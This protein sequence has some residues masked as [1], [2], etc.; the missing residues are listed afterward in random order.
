[1]QQF[2]G[3]FEITLYEECGNDA[4]E[5]YD[6]G[7]ENLNTDFESLITFDN[8]ESLQSIKD[9]LDYGSLYSECTTESSEFPDVDEETSKYDDE[10]TSEDFLEE[11]S[12]LTE[13]L[14]EK[15]S[16]LT[17]VLVGNI[18][19]GCGG[20]IFDMWA[21]FSPP[22][23]DT[24]VSTKQSLS[25]WSHHTDLSRREFLVAKIREAVLRTFR[26]A[27]NRLKIEPDFGI[28]SHDEE[29][30]D[31]EKQRFEIDRI[32]SQSI[33]PA[34]STPI[35]HAQPNFKDKGPARSRILEL[36]VKANP[37][38]DI[39]KLEK[40]ADKLYPSKKSASAYK[41]NKSKRRGQKSNQN[42]QKSNTFDKPPHLIK[43]F[44]P[45]C[46]EGAS[47]VTQDL[48]PI[49]LTETP[50]K[51]TLNYQFHYGYSNQQFLGSI[52]EI[53]AGYWTEGQ[54]YQADFLSE[55]R[56]MYPGQQ[57]NLSGVQ[58]IPVPPIPEQLQSSTPPNL[59]T[60]VMLSQLFT[61]NNCNSL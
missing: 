8:M 54:Y 20:G 17:E 50:P 4:P 56:H 12:D 23:P 36:L 32:G 33:K 40:L 37:I 46:K 19:S 1:M 38:K 42:S 48:Q 26:E 45:R 7:D 52:D 39:R 47:Y 51:C 10:K 11:Y 22:S 61:S 13:V 21:D 44:V 34:A 14:P 25:Y 35:L 3:D 18:L 28:D 15:D 49:T 6:F 41:T 55:P 58:M 16:E 24:V 2:S 53:G 9:K 30:L 60:I 29:Q 57:D 27:R 59:P 31:S 43:E 5:N